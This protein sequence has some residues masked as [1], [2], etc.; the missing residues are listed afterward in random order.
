MVKTSRKE[1]QI[2]LNQIESI[3]HDHFIC[4]DRHLKRAFILQSSG[5]SLSGQLSDFDGKRSRITVKKNR[6]L[7]KR[8]I[9]CTFWK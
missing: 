8:N 4:Q 7:I 3:T 5:R 6:N 1:H 2:R 9:R